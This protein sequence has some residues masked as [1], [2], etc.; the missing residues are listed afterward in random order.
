MPNLQLIKL[1]QSVSDT[2]N[3]SLETVFLS[4]EKALAK[5]SEK[6]IEPG[7]RVSVSI[8]RDTGHPTFTREWTVVENESGIQHPGSE[9]L[10]IDVIDEYPEINVGDI[11]TEELPFPISM[12]RT[13]FLRVKQALI[14]Q[15]GVNKK[16]PLKV[17][18]SK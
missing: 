11:I 16:T 4:F 9:E 2:Q 14:A 15:I 5:V 3:L 18:T 1:A 6:S 13:S 8:N 17:S 12:S 7:A 10:L